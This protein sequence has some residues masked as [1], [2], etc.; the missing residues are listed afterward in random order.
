MGFW[1]N[2]LVIFAVFCAGSLRAELWVP[3]VFSKCAVLQRDMPVPVWGKADP[4]AQITVEFAGQTKQAEILSNG[5]VRVFHPGVPDPVG[6]R[7][8]WFNWGRV[9]LY[10]QAG[11]PAA[12][13]SSKN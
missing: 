13:F 1:K 3:S 8:G 11:L 10:N 6:V 12:P 4:G 2:S 9:S 7:Y 5:V